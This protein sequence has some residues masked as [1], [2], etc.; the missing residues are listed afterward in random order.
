MPVV[1]SMTY[2]VSYVTDPFSTPLLF[3]PPPL[4]LPSTPNPPL[5]LDFPSN[6]ASVLS[7]LAYYLAYI[8]RVT[9]VLEFLVLAHTYISEYTRARKRTNLK[10][11][12]ALCNLFILGR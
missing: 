10:E 3:S 1:N 4:P 7:T 12:L 9:V 6:K 11:I 2:I 5:P 8:L